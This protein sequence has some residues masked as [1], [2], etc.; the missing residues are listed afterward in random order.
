MIDGMVDY[1]RFTPELCYDWKQAVVDVE[2][3]YPHQMKRTLDASIPSQL[4]SKLWVVD[5]LKKIEDRF[6]LQP[7]IALIGG[8]FANYLTPLLIDN[9]NASKVI[10]HEI[11]ND[12]KDISYKY[13][14]RYKDTGQYQCLIKDAMMKE[15]DEIFDIV[16]NTS[17]EHMFPMKRFVEMNKQTLPFNGEQNNPLYVLQSTNDDQY[18]DHI[19]CVSSPEELAEQASI[20]PEYMGSLTLSSGMERFM[21]I[22]R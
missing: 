9:L 17:C 10:N 16:I 4:E 19:N 12:A 3:Y 20:V 11:D 15:L 22:G 5:E 2:R 1:L 13:N 8:W 14:K 6:D 7:T 21:V 18:D